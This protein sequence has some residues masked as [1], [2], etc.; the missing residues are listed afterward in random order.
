MNDLHTTEEVQKHVRAELTKL[1][2]LFDGYGV[3]YVLAVTLASTETEEC[4][5]YEGASLVR[6]NVAHMTAAMQV[7]G[8]MID[9]PVDLQSKILAMV[10]LLI[11]IS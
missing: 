4:L 3:P 2:E 9:L 7:Y 1:M 6:G 10:K 11:S 5:R 8:R